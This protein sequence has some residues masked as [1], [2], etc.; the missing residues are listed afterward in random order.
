M[1][2]VAATQTATARIRGLVH[3][4]FYPSSGLILSGARVLSA[5]VQRCFV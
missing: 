3:F 1:Q 2:N 5:G 4:G